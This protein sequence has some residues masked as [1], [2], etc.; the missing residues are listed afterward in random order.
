MRLLLIAPL[1][2]HLPR[3]LSKRHKQLVIAERLDDLQQQALVLVGDDAQVGEVLLREEVILAA[4]LPDPVVERLLPD[5]ELGGFGVAAL[6]L[7]GGGPGRRG[8]RHGWKG[9]EG[10]SVSQSVPVGDAKGS[11]RRSRSIGRGGLG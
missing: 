1:P 2:A 5:G 4:S 7:G 11:S 9:E 8:G 3:R 6:I 10:E